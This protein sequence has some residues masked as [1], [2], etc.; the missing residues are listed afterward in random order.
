MHG[1]EC[2][3]RSYSYQSRSFE[4]EN[5]A[6]CTSAFLQNK[7]TTM[8]HHLKLVTKLVLI[9]SMPHSNTFTEH[10]PS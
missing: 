3:I 10:N 5:D 2:D 1:P 8:Y 9:K 7:S 6:N 4:L